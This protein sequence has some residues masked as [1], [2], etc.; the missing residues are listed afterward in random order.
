MK[1]NLLILVLTFCAFSLYAQK[2][3]KYFTVKQLP[4]AYQFLPP[5]PAFDSPFFN[6]DMLMYEWGKS[7]RPTPRG[8]IAKDDAKYSVKRMADIFSDI[9][10]VQI[11]KENTPQIWKLLKNSVATVGCSDSIAKATYMR[12]RPFMYTGETSMTPDDEKWL[13]DNGSYPSGHTLL[14]W[15]TALILVE[16]NPDAADQ[17]LKRGYEY[18]QSRV[19]VGAH[20]QS[21]VDAGR[22]VA[23]AAFA[24][25]Q[26]SK[27]YQKQLHKAQKEYHKKAKSTK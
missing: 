20:W 12:P 15:V 26:T 10:Q 21:D 13:R 27:A 16:V 1:R 3:E 23:S 19:I 7:M 17:L 2:T 22:L 4:D 24:R 9:M 18:G 25:L 11:S 5:P 14:G 6:H 8:Q